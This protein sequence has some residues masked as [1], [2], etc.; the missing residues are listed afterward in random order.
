MEEEDDSD[1]D[2]DGG[3]KSKSKKKGGAAGAGGNKPKPAAV[4]LPP[5]EPLVASFTENH[6]DTTVDFSVTATELAKSKLL[7]TCPG[8]SGAALSPA[9]KKVFKLETSISANNMMLFDANGAI[10][11]FDS[12]VQII[13]VRTLQN[14]MSDQFNSNSFCYRIQDFYALRMLFY[15]KRHA[16]LI[17]QMTDAVAALDNKVRFILAVVRG[18]LKI[19]NRKRSELL[20]ELHDAGYRGLGARAEAEALAAAAAAAPT[21]DGAQGGPADAV[22]DAD[23][24]TLAPSGEPLRVLAA[25]YNYL[26][27]LPLWSLTLEKVQQLRAELA[28]N[29]VRPLLA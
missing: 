20:A 5:G 12:T 24:G 25:R 7:C 23:D 28:I 6:T 13:E 9:V 14:I 15:E 22:A 26:L 18:E 8:A 19:A 16:H 11:R 17:A 29:E 4:E 21:G 10:K 3:G 27:S 2:G 1:S